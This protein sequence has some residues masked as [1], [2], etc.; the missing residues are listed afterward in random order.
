M[1]RPKLGEILLEMGAINGSDLAHALILQR[2]LSARLGDVLLRRGLVDDEVLADAL[3]RQRG[4]GRAGP[5]PQDCPAIDALARSLPLQVALTF[6]ALPWDR[7]GGRT[8]IATSRPEALDDLRA[9]LPESFGSCL[10]AV[11]TDG[12]LDARM[13]QVHGASLARSAE[14]R[15]PEGLSCRLW[16]SRPGAAILAIFLLSV[17]LATLV[18]PTGALRIATALALMVMSA[19][20]GLRV[21]A[22]LAMRRKPMGFN[23]IRP[24]EQSARKLP[25]ITILVPLH[26]EPDIAAPLTKRLAR[27]DYP[28]E[29]LDICLVVEADD[30]QTRA[31][32]NRADLPV[33]MR[34]IPVPDGHPRTK[35][36]AMNY[37]LTFARGTIVGIYDAEDAPAADQLLTVAARFRAAPARVAC[38]QG[39]L[40]Y[41]NPTRNW[42]SR[43]FTIE[44]ANWFR[45]IL[46]GIARLGLVVPLGGT[47]LFFRRSALER[48]G[49]WDAHNVTEDAD[50]GVRLARMGYRTE[51]I[52][53][54]T[55]EEAN[56]SPFAWIK[57][58][59]RWMKGYILTWA[60]HSRRP[61]RLW[62]DI[63]PRRFFGFHLLFLGSIL[64][65]VLLP[66]L[67]ST[68]IM[69]FGIP[70]PISDWLPGNGAIALGTIMASATVLSITLSWIAC[71]TLHHRRLRR[72]I[73]TMELYF[74]LASIAILK[75][76]T[77][78]VLRPFHWD[79]TAHGG[80]GGVDQGDIGTLEDSLALTDAGHLT[81][82]SGRV[83]RMA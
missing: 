23:S 26:Q 49:A 52:Q 50:L 82:N 8:L 83:T 9:A 80:F 59:S 63:G 65:A 76:L 77:E 78:I 48:V 32:L 73:P 22:A 61:A 12:A 37:A 75:A 69:L 46:P 15:V 28:R 34:V 2:R 42:M 39:L 54:T 6:R 29:L 19:N 21:A 47:T 72:W 79:K 13:H 81:R 31:A 44:Y 25:C 24:A 62:K 14:C 51:I 18:W 35:P 17:L 36:R 67:W 74:P 66:V 20:L 57:Q 71:S 27:L 68:I 16:G 7:V 40:D 3:G 56:A 70:H 60:V 4:L 1:R 43:C 5:A 64:N 58:R 45:L 53:T 10:F 11:V 38:L 41:Y 30:A 33:W 55:L